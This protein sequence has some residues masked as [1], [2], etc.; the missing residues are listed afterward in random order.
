MEIQPVA[1][2][3]AN[4]FCAMPQM[5]VRSANAVKIVAAFLCI[6]ITTNR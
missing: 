6:S 2:N 4:V 5:H 1:V 3:A